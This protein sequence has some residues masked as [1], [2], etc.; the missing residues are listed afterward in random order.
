MSQPFTIEPRPYRL[1]NQIQHYAWGTMGDEAYIP[2]LLGVTPEPGLS[3]AELWMGAHPNAPSHICLGER[4]VSL[5]EA[6]ARHPVALLG[7]EVNEAFAG[8]LPFLFKVLSAGQALSI[9][10]HPDQ[11]QAAALHARDPAHYPDPNHKPE[12]AIALESLTALLGFRPYGGILEALDRYPE[13]AQST[14]AE[15]LARF[16]A[17]DGAH[18]AQREECLRELFASILTRAAAEPAILERHTAALARRVKAANGALREEEALFLALRDQYGGAD[19][20]LLAVFLLNR[21]HLTEG[22]GVYIGPGIPHAYLRGNIVECMA[23]S[24]NVVRVGLTPKYRDADALI[25]ILDCHMGPVPV[26]EGMAAEEV[27]YHTPASEFL[28]S[29][30]RLPHGR[31]KRAGLHD[32][33]EILLVLRG[34]LRVRWEGGEEVYRQG[35]SMLLP[36]CLQG[37]ALE[38]LEPV[39][40]FRA[41]V[42]R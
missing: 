38:A 9:Q 27:V 18:T 14:R 19:V 12:L 34:R 33:P 29:R 39:S 21:V 30:W 28:V 1:Y 24:D 36:A 25:E 10:A 2:R 40:V 16:R 8:T 35:A 26:L 22:E 7:P 11:A 13:L 4:P 17:A 3:Y 20:G 6:I 23:N 37:A 15:A 31:Q 32:R 5:R 41:E 42:P